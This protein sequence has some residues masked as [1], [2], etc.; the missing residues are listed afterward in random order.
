[1]STFLNGYFG[2]P[3]EMAK[4]PTQVLREPKFKETGVTTPEEFVAAA[5]HLVYIYPTWQWATGEGIPTDGK[6]FLVTK[7]VP[8]KWCTQM[9]YSDEL[10]AT[11][12]DDGDGGWVESYHNTGIAG[13]TEAVKE[14]TLESKDNIILQDC[15]AVCEEEEEEE[16]G[17][18]ADMKVYGESGFL[19]TDE[20]T[21]D[22]RELVEA[23]KAKTDA[24][25]ED[26]IS[27]IR[28]YNIYIT[29]DKYYQTPGLQLFRYPSPVEHMC[30]NISQDHVKKTGANENHHH[31]PLPPLCSAP[32]KKII[33][34]IAK[35]GGLGVPM[36]LLIFLKFVQAVLPTIQNYTR[37]F[38][39]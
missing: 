10:E 16:E 3:L 26:A 22:T 28:T 23:C 25:G 18:A 31:L 6:Q 2:K 30:E 21:L 14:I 20:A 39:M 35:G 36:H 32:M 4:Y 19:E 15:S 5:D 27:Q 37:H 7:N 9:E 12:E 29:Y 11:I 34:T 33:E 8:C 13:I 38:T 17:E 1:F 24:G